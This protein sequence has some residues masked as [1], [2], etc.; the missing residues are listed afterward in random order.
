M[1]QKNAFISPNY[2][3]LGKIGKTVDIDVPL[4]LRAPQEPVNLKLINPASKVVVIKLFPG[5][6]QKYTDS[7][8]NNN[9]VHAVVL[10]TFGDG[11]IPTS[12][13]FI[14]SIEYMLKKGVIV[15]NASQCLAH[16][17]NHK[18]SI[19]ALLQDIGVVPAHDLTTEAAVTK[20]YFLLGNVKKQEVIPK[21]MTINMRG[22]LI[23][24]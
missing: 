22:E 2:P 9:A 21:L 15:V 5:I 14:Q 23:P 19:G 17:V 12:E 1:F 6:T 3:V 10:E 20:L 13:A 8:I 24:N 18:N 11:D 16:K 4:V 7:I